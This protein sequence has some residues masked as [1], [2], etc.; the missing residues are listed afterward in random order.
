MDANW[1]AAIASAASAFVVAVAAIAAL[2]QIRHAR[3]ANDITIYLRLLDRLDSPKTTAA[4]AA[5]ER[6]SEK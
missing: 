4:F 3:N 1:V 2:V 6:I 5:I